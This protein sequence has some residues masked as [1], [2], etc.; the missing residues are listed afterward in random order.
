MVTD[1]DPALKDQGDYPFAVAHHL[2][3]ARERDLLVP[4]D[5]ANPQEMNRAMNT[6]I[7]QDYISEAMNRYLEQGGQIQRI[8]RVAGEPVMGMDFL[9]PDE[10]LEMTDTQEADLY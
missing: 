10:I 5:S 1:T 4:L 6:E 9:I 2:L 7:T 3:W 8:D